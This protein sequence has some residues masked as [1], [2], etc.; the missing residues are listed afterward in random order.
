[1]RPR[2]EEEEEVIWRVKGFMFQLS[3]IKIV[4]QFLEYITK[5]GHFVK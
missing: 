3:L 4:N 5:A 1:L 2:A